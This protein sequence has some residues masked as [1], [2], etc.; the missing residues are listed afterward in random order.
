MTYDDPDAPGPSFVHAED[1][2]ETLADLEL[3]I[4]PPLHLEWRDSR[5]VPPT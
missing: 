5:C 4:F 1:K 2:I 3:V